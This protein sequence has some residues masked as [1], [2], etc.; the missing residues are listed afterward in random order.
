MPCTVIAENA[1]PIT[2]VAIRRTN[3]RTPCAI[4]RGAGCVETAFGAGARIRFARSVVRR[5]R[6]EILVT[7]A[8]RTGIG[9]R[10]R[11]VA[12]AGDEERRERKTKKAHCSAR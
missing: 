8:V 11:R 6:V 1:G 2:S 10:G 5:L 3:I 4:E 12:T 9:R 7:E